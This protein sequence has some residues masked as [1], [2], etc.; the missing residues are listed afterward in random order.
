MVSSFIQLESKGGVKGVDGE[1]S[2]YTRIWC[3][4]QVIIY[5]LE[6]EISCVAIPLPFTYKI[7][8][9]SH[10]FSIIFT[11][12]LCLTKLRSSIWYLF[13]AYYYRQLFAD[14]KM[15]NYKILKL[16]FEFCF[17]IREIVYNYDAIYDF[18]VNSESIM[19]IRYW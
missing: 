16:F 1:N 11:H 4:I 17:N 8:S 5:P 12:F 6:R 9:R 19:S 10:L 2:Y 7:L 13:I 3:N 15:E 14:M 18:S